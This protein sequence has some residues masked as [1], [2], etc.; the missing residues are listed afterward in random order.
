MYGTVVCR[1]RQ[2]NLYIILVRKHLLKRV[3]G[4][5]CC[6]FSVQEVWC[7]VMVRRFTERI[8]A[9][10]GNMLTTIRLSTAAAVRRIS[11]DSVIKYDSKI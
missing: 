6:I 2:V 5:F 7:W 1:F 10:E 11:P 8:Q 4:L 9:S 3:F